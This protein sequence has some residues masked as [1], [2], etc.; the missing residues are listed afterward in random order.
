MKLKSILSVV[1]L[2]TAVSLFG[3]ELINGRGCGT[4]LPP[5]GWDEAFNQKVEEFKQLRAANKTQNTTYVIPVIV[6]VIY[7]NQNVGTYPNLSQAQINSQI[8]AL[9]EDF[10]GIGFNSGN[11]QSTVF[12]NL[13]ANTDVSFCLAQLDPDGNPLAEP[14]IDRV[15]YTALGLSNPN[16]SAY[17]NSNSFQTYMNG[18]I[19]PA[20]IW[21]PTRY[22]NIWVSDRH[23]NTGLLGYATFPASSGLSGISGSTGTS[24]T[25][26][27]WVW[28]RAFGRTG[29]LSYPYNKGRTA[30]HEIGH[31]LGLRHISGD[32]ACGNDFCNDTP[33]QK[34]GN[35][36][37]GLNYDCPTYPH[38]VSGECTGINSATSVGSEMFMNFMDYVDDACMY[39]F[40][41][42]QTAR[43]QTAMTYGT[44]RKD[45]T[46]SSQI[47]CSLSSALA[48]SDFA[49]DEGIICLD[50]E[51]TPNNN[52]TGV[53][54]PTYSWSANNPGV[55]FNPSSSA[56]TPTLSFSEGGTYIITLAASN[57]EGTTSSSQILVV[58][59]CGLDVGLAK[60]SVLSK[61]MSLVP[62]PASD[63]VTVQTNLPDNSIV[64]VDLYNALGELLFSK[65]Y[66]YTSNTSIRLDLSKYPSGV[67]S[68]IVNTNEGRVSKKLILNK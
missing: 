66:N 64:E 38:L 50:E 12:A 26:G 63:A 23:N 35:M 16:S 55:T 49:F 48:T 39:M 15:S 34:G 7:G 8:D 4:P 47:V 20:T 52:S 17:N 10:A 68:V 44:Y 3:Q 5:A 6:H 57:S 46:A 24:S 37:P 40:T 36:T 13:V 1:A 33:T 43:I 27:V 2:S 32:Q 53:P 45:L 62:N 59:N 19:K 61:N 65:K 11:A 30:T 22:F 42:D 60:I 14:G 41:P 25:D 56:A 9:N 31:W 18:T 58:D 54:A 51:I 29:T 28:G 21:D 67:Y